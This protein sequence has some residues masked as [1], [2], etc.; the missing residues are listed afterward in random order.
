MRSHSQPRH[1]QETDSFT[2]L[3]VPHN[4]SPVSVLGV[5]GGMTSYIDWLMVLS[6]HNGWL[7]SKNGF[8]KFTKKV[9]ND[10]SCAVRERQHVCTNFGGGR[11]LPDLSVPGCGP[12]V[13]SDVIK[14]VTFETE[15]WLKVRDQDF[16]NPETE[17]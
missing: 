2:S 3:L 14:M 15:I 1:V 4:L 8:E 12:G 5:F 11:Q 17:T 10:V 16:K 13:D 9:T 6:W 7:V